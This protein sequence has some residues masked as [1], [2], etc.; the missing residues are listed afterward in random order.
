MAADPHH[1][2]DDAPN[3]RNTL[4][5]CRNVSKLSVCQNIFLFFTVQTPQDETWSGLRVSLNLLHLLPNPLN[6][7]ISCFLRY[8]L[9]STPASPAQILQSIR[10]VASP[11]WRL[12]FPYMTPVNTLSQRLTPPVVTATLDKHEISRVIKTNSWSSNSTT[13]DNQQQQTWRE[14]SAAGTDSKQQTS[15]KWDAAELDFQCDG[16]RSS[17]VV[18]LR[19]WSWHERTVVSSFTHVLKCGLSGSCSFTF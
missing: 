14:I 4:I 8:R 9:S 3:V 11:S 13:T 15:S 18:F 2:S 1:S 16:R 7:V 10:C 17:A 5:F 12:A 19:A 6:L